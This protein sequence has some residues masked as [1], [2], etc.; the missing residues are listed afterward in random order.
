MVPSAF[1]WLTQ[2]PLTTQGKV[3]RQALP[4][5]DPAGSSAA[6]AGG[7]AP[8]TPEE[9]L[10]AGI[11]TEVLGLTTVGVHDDFF[12]LGGHSLLA[13]Q[14]I[15]RI[16]RVFGV[17]L[18]LSVL[19]EAPTLARLAERVETARQ[20]GAPSALVALQ[21]RG[22]RRPLVLA[23]G[24]W[25]DLFS[26]RDLAAR[27]GP[28]QPIYGFESPVG[29]NGAAALRTVEAL[30][31]D[32][33]R[34]LR[35]FQPEGPY[36]LCGYCWAGGMAFE[37]ARQLRSAGHEV[38]LLAL[39]DSS[40]PGHRLS[41]P[42]RRRSKSRARDLWERAWR[43]LHRLRTLRPRAM[44]GFLGDRIGN[45][46]TELAGGLAFRLS[47][48]LGRA[49]LPQLRTRYGALS[50]AGRLYRPQPYPGR[51][52]LFRAHPESHENGDLHWGWDRV[53]TGGVELCLL[54]GEHDTIMEDPQVDALAS[55]LRACLER[56]QMP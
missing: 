27:L 20:R 43:N 38:A 50:H 40:C 48:R 56:A 28:D 42:V 29:P 44:P 47:L 23:H 37:M 46:V 30:A 7:V 34:E 12:T 21:P 6:P 19:F 4:A 39:I 25:G 1:V 32:Y 53:A 51:V 36:F 9:K 26:Y 22:S 5:P 52:T 16:G 35:A 55:S 8:R 14:V 31:A 45:L 33:V 54:D 2:L 13:T 3:D 10:L 17:E 18:P 49:V 11:W 15:S 41:P 24:A